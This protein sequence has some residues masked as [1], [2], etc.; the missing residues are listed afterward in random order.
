MAIILALI[1]TL[2]L[3]SVRLVAPLVPKFEP[4][5]MWPRM[6]PGRTT[7]GYTSGFV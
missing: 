7:Y 3:A 4:I 2:V 5:P 1:L 6:L